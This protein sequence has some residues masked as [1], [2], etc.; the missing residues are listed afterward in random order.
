MFISFNRNKNSCYKLMIKI[1][2]KKKIIQA[3]NQL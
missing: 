1:R 3:N 2:R